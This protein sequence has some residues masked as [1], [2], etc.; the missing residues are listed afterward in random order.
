MS[1]SQSKPPTV[2]KAPPKER[3]FPCA[4]CGARLDF[5]PSARSLKCPYCGYEELIVPDQEG[6]QERDFESYLNMLAKEARLEGRSSQVRCTG[7]GAV[8]LLEDKVVTEKCPFCATHLENEPEAAES[9]V[10]PESVL[11]FRIDSRKAREAFNAWIASRWFAPNSLKKMANLGQLSGVYLPYWTFDSMTYSHYTGQRGDNYTTFE[12]DSKGR[13]RTVVRTRWYPVS[14]EIDHFFDDVLVCGSKSLPTGRVRD[15]EPWDLGHLVTFMPEYLSGFKTER[16]AVGLKD[17]FV[18][19]QGIM[20][21]RIHRL[22]EQDIGGDHQLVEHVN[23][24]H[25]GVTFKHILLP[26]WLATYRY[27]D[28]V[29]RI[30]VNARTGEVVGERPWSF[31]KIALVVLAVAAIV[32]A[33]L[34]AIVSF[35]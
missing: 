13:V 32:A 2:S 27:Y 20:S 30:L 9:M 19:A 11:P 28:K 21:E 4:K 5:N 17:G 18:R 14:G 1:D 3:K 6:V 15:L 22:C 12:T 35:Q 10:V 33:V 8:V 24:Q 25:V 29:Y 23:T 26:L 31:W 7:C 34:L 16:Y